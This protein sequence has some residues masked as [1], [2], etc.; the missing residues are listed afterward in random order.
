MN[1]QFM[2]LTIVSL[3]SILLGIILLYI[4][5]TQTCPKPEIQ[6]RYIKRNQY[7]DPSYKYNNVYEVD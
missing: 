6:Y 2:H 7:E 1:C 4:H 5:K 3:F